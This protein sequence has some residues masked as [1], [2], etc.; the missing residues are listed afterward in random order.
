MKE[1]LPENL[2]K[3]FTILRILYAAES[4]PQKMVYGTILRIFYAVENHFILEK[5]TWNTIQNIE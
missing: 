2:G 5:R 1:F 4:F 3:F